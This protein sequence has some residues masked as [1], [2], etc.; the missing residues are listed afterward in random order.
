MAALLQMNAR[1]DEWFKGS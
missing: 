1:L